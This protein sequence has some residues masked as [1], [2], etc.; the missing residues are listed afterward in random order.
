M[1]LLLISDTK[2]KVTLTHEDMKRLD[3]SCDGLDYDNTQT[4]RAFWQILDEA[5]SKTGF[6]A[7]RDRVFIQVYPSKCGGC[8]MYVIKLKGLLDT[9]REGKKEV[10][11]TRSSVF[12]FDSISSLLPV[13]RQLK[14]LGYERESAAYI[15]DDGRYYLVVSE[16]APLSGQRGAFGEFSF[17]EEYGRRHTEPSRTAY[18]RE[19]C[20]VI[21]ASDAVNILAA[22]A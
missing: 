10:S 1:E 6:D 2:L 22:L 11:K 4:R 17:L 16:E 19:H 13:C 15:G 14:G 8:E 18:I 9:E 3:I 5:K 20:Q 21:D 12:S 7:A